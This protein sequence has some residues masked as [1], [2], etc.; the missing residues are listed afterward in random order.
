MPNNGRAGFNHDNTRATGGSVIQFMRT[1]YSLLNAVAIAGLLVVGP[2]ASASG[3]EQESRN[4]KSIA[5]PDQ[6]IAAIFNLTEGTK[7]DEL[8]NLERP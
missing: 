4:P 7:Q 3:A 5:S 1:R 6:R 8:A 2:A